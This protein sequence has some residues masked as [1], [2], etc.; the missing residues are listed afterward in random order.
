MRTVALL[1]IALV[2]LVPSL[3]LSDDALAKFKGGIGADG[4]SVPLDSPCRDRRHPQHRPRRATPAQLWAIADF[5]RG[6][7]RRAHQG[8]TGGAL[9]SPGATPSGQRSC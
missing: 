8:R 5:K 4:V 9:C 3:G 7:N 2:A 1:A 6:E